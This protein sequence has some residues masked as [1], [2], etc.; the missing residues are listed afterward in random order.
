MPVV[1]LSY[2]RG[3]LTQAQKRQLARDLTEIALDAEVDAVTDNGRAV[4]VVH[5][6]EAAAEDWAVGGELRSTAEGAP[7]HF[8][9]DVVVL[10][11]L[12]EGERRRAVHRRVTEAFVAACGGK[13]ADPMLALRVWV[14]VHEVREGSWGAAGGTVSA[15]DV[16]QFLRADLP[17]ERREEITAAIGGGPG[18]GG[19]HA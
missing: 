12:L 10:Q 6:H 13:D 18:G 4:T 17:A 8:V 5:F 1:R 9:V 2:P 11:G 3:A 7:N 16:A 14:L 15:L 19:G